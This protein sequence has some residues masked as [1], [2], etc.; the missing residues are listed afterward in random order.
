[1]DFFNICFSFVVGLAILFLYNYMK[2]KGEDVATKEDIGQITE[3]IEKI[4]QDF[5]KETEILKSQL[6]ISKHS[7]ISMNEIKRNVI[8]DYFNSYS[9]W[10]SSIKNYV[11]PS[12]FVDDYIRTTF[13]GLD[14]MNTL[15]MRFENSES[16]LCFFIVDPKFS[17]I[18]TLLKSYTH[19]LQL[20]REKEICIDQKI[21][22]TAECYISTD[23]DK[24][25]ETMGLRL[26][27]IKKYEKLEKEHF[28][29]IYPKYNEMRDFLN[30]QYQ[31]TL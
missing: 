8:M 9:S 17:T 22:K 19:V 14:H 12:L 18:S 29:K 24:Y 5:V 11:Q 7:I 6:D 26:D 21:F 28:E 30:K 4:K 25:N 15:M 20:D 3:V 10:L 31:A 13:I 16:Q 1:M 23:L 27:N 2:K